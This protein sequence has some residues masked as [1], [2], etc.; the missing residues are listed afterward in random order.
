MSLTPEQATQAYQ[1]LITPF[2]AR[3]KLIA[4]AVHN[5]NGPAMGLNWLRSFLRLCRDCN[6]SA[7]AV[8]WH[9]DTSDDFKQFLHQALDLAAQHGL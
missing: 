7:L 1:Q 6:V 5:G 9:G 8:R 3:A 2:G 4:P